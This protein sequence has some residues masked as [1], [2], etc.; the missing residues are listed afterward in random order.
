MGKA[1]SI[2]R[3]NQVWFAIQLQFSAHA[4]AHTIFH[5]VIQM[6][7]Q[8]YQWQLVRVTGEI[9]TESQKVF[10][11]I[12]RSTR[13]STFFSYAMLKTWEQLVRGDQMHTY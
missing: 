2:W 12:I 9:T 3:C 1:E 4:L 5:M 11:H 10:N 6:V 8:H 7:L 13:P